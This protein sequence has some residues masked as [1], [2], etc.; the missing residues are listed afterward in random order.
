MLKDTDTQGLT[1]A[2]A[3]KLVKVSFKFMKFS[4]PD[5]FQYPSIF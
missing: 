2:K 5:I 4:S 3:L 1:E